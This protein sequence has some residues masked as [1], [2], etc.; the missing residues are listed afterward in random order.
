MALRTRTLSVANRGLRPF[1][2]QLSST[3]HDWDDPTQF[4]PFERTLHDSAAAGLTV[5][6]YV[7]VAFNEAGATQAAID[8]MAALGAFDRPIASVCE[9]GPGSGRYLAKVLQLCRP[10][11]VEIYETARPWA[12][13]LVDTYGVVAQPS[14]GSTLA[15]TESGSV[16]LVMSH[17]VFVATTTLVTFRYLTEMARVLRPGGTAI[18]DVV[19]ERCLSVEQIEDWLASGVH[20]GPYPASIPRECITALLAHHH[21]V[22]NGSFL[23]P[24]RPGLTECMVYRRTS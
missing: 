19:T 18:F 4:L 12:Q 11:R 6:D 16:D 9:I 23:E 3:D 17:K 10:A 20:S 8:Q 22:F 13:Y 5:A 7:D 24:M 15:S 14:D 21:L 2:I 1:R